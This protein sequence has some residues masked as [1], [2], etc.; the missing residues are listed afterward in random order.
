MS[1]DQVLEMSDPGC[2]GLSL[3]FGGWKLIFEVY[4]E[5]R[6]NFRGHLGRDCRSF[7]DLRRELDGHCQTLDD[8][9]R[10]RFERGEVEQLASDWPDTQRL[11]VALDA[12][13]ESGFF[14]QRRHR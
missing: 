11:R 12:L 8:I 4:G 10:P 14:F 13:E 3:G 7:S 6:I 5:A 1:V 9:E 2:R